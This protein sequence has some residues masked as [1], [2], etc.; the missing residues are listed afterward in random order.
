[1]PDEDGDEDDEVVADEVVWSVDMVGIVM[2][3]GIVELSEVVA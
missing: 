2:D 1:M 3:I